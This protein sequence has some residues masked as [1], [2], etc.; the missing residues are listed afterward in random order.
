MV[1]ALGSQ[2]QELPGPPANPQ[3]VKA[4]QEAAAA[5]KTLKETRE[6]S[7]YPH[8]IERAAEDATVSRLRLHAIA[9][10]GAGPRGG[11]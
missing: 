3:L 2:R 4:V 6:R 1:R 10:F 8:E 5:E 9:Q 11:A 7:A